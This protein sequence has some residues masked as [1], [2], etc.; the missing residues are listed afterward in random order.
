MSDE[1]EKKKLLITN[2]ANNKK[3]AVEEKARRDQLRRDAYTKGILREA[4][5]QNAVDSLNINKQDLVDKIAIYDEKIM[6]QIELNGAANEE[7]I[8]ARETM[9]KNLTETN[10][11][12]AEK[13]NVGV[14][15]A[16]MTGEALG[17]ALSSMFAGNTQDAVDSVRKLAASLLGVLA[18]SLSKEVSATV[19]K[20]VLKQLQ[21]TAEINPIGA[22]LLGATITPLINAGVH[23][24]ADPIINDI[25]AF[26][27]GGDISGLYKSPT[28]ILVGDGSK[29][30]G[31]NKEWILRDDQLKQ[32]VTM[33]INMQN[34]NLI[35]EVQDLKRIMQNQS[36]E[37]KIKGEDIYVTQRRNSVSRSARMR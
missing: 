14:E 11:I 24:I 17:D 18:E 20:I 32:T 37:T 34:G 23:A 25:L 5:R 31:N 13:T 9:A 4:E 12:L 21:W 35:S 28:R 3:I 16:K 2:E 7:D 10:R 29:L 15:V 8:K 1:Y 36:L 22:A 33:A 27:T 19:L 30:G 26:P 6:A